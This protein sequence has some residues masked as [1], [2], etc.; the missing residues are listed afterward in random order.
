[1]ENNILDH[2]N[3]LHKQGNIV[4]MRYSGKYAVQFLDY[5]YEDSNI[6]LNR[7]YEKYIRKKDDEKDNE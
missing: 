2:Y 1:M 6:Y 3:K 4:I 5:I 7:K